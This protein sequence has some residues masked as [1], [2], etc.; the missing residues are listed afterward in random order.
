[1]KGVT[2]GVGSLSFSVQAVCRASVMDSWFFKAKSFMQFLHTNACA[3]CGARCHSLRRHVAAVLFL[4]LLGGVLV[5]QSVSAEAGQGLLLEELRDGRIGPLQPSID[6]DL[7][8]PSVSDQH[9]GGEQVRIDEVQFDGH[10]VFTEEQLRE[11]LGDYAGEP[12]DLS[13]LHGLAA[14]I[15][16][17]YRQQGYPFATALLPEQTISDNTL[18]IRVL[19]G[20]YGR[21][22][23]IDYDQF[24]EPAQA[25]LA[26]LVPGDVIERRALERTMLILGD[27]PGIVA[28]PAMRPGEETGTGDLGVEV[29]PAPQVRGGVRMDNHGN[30]FSG[31]YRG[32]VDLAANRLLMFGDELTLRAFYTDEDLWLGD[33]AY[34]LPLGTSGL[35]GEVGVART[36][37]ALGEDLLGLEGTATIGSATLTYPFIRQETGNLIGILGYEYKALDDQFLG[38]S[39]DEKTVQSGSLG[40]RFDRRD[41]IL[42][43]GVTYGAA[44]LSGG[45]VSPTDDIAAF[46]EAP[47]DGGFAKLLLQLTR[48][49]RLPAG[50]VL[51][52]SGMVQRADGELDSSEFMTLGGAGG[53]RAF[54][55]GEAA[56]SEAALLQ[57]ELSYQIGWGL[58]P[59]V[60]HDVGRVRAEDSAPQGGGRTISGAGLGLR[61]NWGQ[62]SAEVVSAWEGA[63]GPPQADQRN[64][65]PRVWGRVGYRF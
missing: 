51:E 5:P 33:L 9:P 55:Q 63:G 3:Q 32:Q 62:M 52:L 15:T 13:G 49:Q 23:A 22:E 2:S 34:S 57:S 31:A 26:S 61:G 27:V 42:G 1:M 24:A 17:F 58:T 21:V 6:L 28:T 18:T 19:E 29:E 43:G 30:R 48:Q 64:Q 65:D 54:P 53:V 7:D 47:G 36:E 16:R 56:G 4:G 59:F 8:V 20:R 50:F 14:R 12:F 40:V 46:G 44:V 41:G 39:F 60:F 37:Y 25:Y 11:V 10:S 45:D 35:R 38:Q